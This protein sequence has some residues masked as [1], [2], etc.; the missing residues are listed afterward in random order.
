MSQLKGLKMILL[1]WD[2]F[3]DLQCFMDSEK[4]WKKFN[5]YFS[6][7]KAIL[8]VNAPKIALLV[9]YQKHVPDSLL[10]LIWCKYFIHFY[11]ETRNHSEYASPISS[12]FKFLLEM[13]SFTC[14][15]QE[16]S[17]QFKQPFT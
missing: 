16:Y 9:T 4:G 3:L 1:D 8:K 6:A 10:Q 2:S 7:Q 14:M 17:R 5:A 15:L 12:L 11:V 13:S